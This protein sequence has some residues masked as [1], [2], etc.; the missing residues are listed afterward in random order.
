MD[1]VH[2]IRR[3]ARS[4]APDQIP[5]AP[6]H[7]VVVV[8]NEDSSSRLV[9]DV[10]SAAT[11]GRPFRFDTVVASTVAIDAAGPNIP[12]AIPIHVDDDYYYFGGNNIP[13]FVP[14]AVRCV[15]LLPCLVRRSVPFRLGGQHQ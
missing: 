3:H 1:N 6:W 11:V 12:A 15:S 2:G 5:F 9:D 13:P 8:V 10:P 7:G 4:F 14:P